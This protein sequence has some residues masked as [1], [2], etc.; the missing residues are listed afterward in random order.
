MQHGASGNSA[1]AHESPKALCSPFPK[2]G[3]K[4]DPGETEKEDGVGKD[5]HRCADQARE[6]KDFPGHGKERVEKVGGEYT[7]DA[8]LR[9]SNGKEEASGL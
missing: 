6:E 1:R 8:H 4:R 5:V 2:G 7:P 3:K 9:K